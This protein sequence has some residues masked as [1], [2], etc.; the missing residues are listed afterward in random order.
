MKT[1]IECN[2]LPF[3]LNPLNNPIIKGTAKTFIHFCTTESSK[4]EASYQLLKSKYSKISNGK[5]NI[6][7]SNECIIN[8]E[9]SPTRESCI[10]W[11]RKNSVNNN[12]YNQSTWSI[13]FQR[14]SLSNLSTL[15]HLVISTRHNHGLA[16]A[17]KTIHTADCDRSSSNTNCKS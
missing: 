6:L 14:S 3:F 1:S 7:K 13:H 2:K 17:S 12:N 8:R 10:I 16:V 15:F 9:I 11:N 4:H 5:T